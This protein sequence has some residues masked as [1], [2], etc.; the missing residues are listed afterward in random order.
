LSAGKLDDV[1]DGTGTRILRPAV[2]LVAAMVVLGALLGIVWAW[3]SPPVPE[4][5]HLHG[6]LLRQESEA[7]MAADARF[8]LLT[9]V[10][11]LGIGI[12]AWFVRAARGPTM[13]I[14]LAVGG[15]LGAYSTAVI[16]TA[17][18]GGTDDAP[19][20][21]AIAHLELHVQATGGYYI[22]AALA[23]VMYSLL[24]AFAADDDLGRPDPARA[25]AHARR[26]P[27]ALAAA[28]GGVEDARG[29]GDAAGATQ[30]HDFAPQQPH[31]PL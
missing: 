6:G 28:Q 29:H 25:A 30:Q 27:A 24:V 16:G 31:Q 15:L 11:G 23:V 26:Q 19:I 10:V 18:G 20:G 12:A 5:V 2:V 4:G 9:S 8:V 17:V 3:W 21:T 13:V 14:G 7:F 1:A 22:E